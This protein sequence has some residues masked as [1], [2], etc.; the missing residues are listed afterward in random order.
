MKIIKYI[1]A[2]LFKDFYF[3]FL[4]LYASLLGLAT[5]NLIQKP[6]KDYSSF[7]TVPVYIGITILINCLIVSILTDSFFGE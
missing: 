6:H 1:K 7:I 4:T 2:Y 5:G 3:R